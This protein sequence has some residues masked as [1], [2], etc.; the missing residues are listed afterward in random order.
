MMRRDTSITCTEVEE[1]LQ[2][3]ALGA[4]DANERSQVVAHL[5]AC[6]SCREQFEQY[7]QVSRGLLGAA[8]QRM[9]PPALKASLMAQVQE[10]ARQQPWTERLSR[11]LR[12]TLSVP[13]WATGALSVATAVM[14]LAAVVLGAQVARLSTQYATLTQQLQEQQQIL[15]VL[16]GS[17]TVAMTMT[18]TKNADGA[19]AT[20]RFNP[21]ETHAVLQTHD[22]PV[23]SADRAYQL[24][25]IDETGKRDSGA[26]FTVPYGSGGETTLLV[27]APRPL[28]TYTR[29]GVSIEPYGGSPQPTGPQALASKAWSYS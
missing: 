4:L 3:L 23:L 29:C 26:V 17:T 21:M 11:W 22:L 5:D 7:A 2:A 13:R 20:L 27:V 24:W 18:G 6:P 12:D 10:T 19:S 15:S 28:R 25:L 9:P 14:L 16:T 1:V 8:P